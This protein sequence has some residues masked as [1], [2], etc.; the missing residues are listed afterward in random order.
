LLLAP[1]RSFELSK[2][3]NALEPRHRITITIAISCVE[4]LWKG[5]AA[6]STV[7]AGWRK[8]YY[9][10]DRSTNELVAASMY[11]LH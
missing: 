9:F 1:W 8:N 3:R 4:L 11:Y 6:K 2:W 5:L 7:C 10:K